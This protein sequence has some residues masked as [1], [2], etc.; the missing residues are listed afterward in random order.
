M[1]EETKKLFN[2]PWYVDI[3]AVDGIDGETY[4]FDGVYNDKCELVCGNI[5]KH[6]T[7]NR[8]AH[9]PELYDALT[10]AIARACSEC[11]LEMLEPN[12]ECKKCIVDTWVKLLN[13]VKEGK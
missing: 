9:L 4:V 8:L 1:T 2:A 10:E 6:A 11:D 5:Q 3:H 13:K 12:D 7:S